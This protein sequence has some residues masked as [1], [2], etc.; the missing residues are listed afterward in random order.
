MS[1]LESLAAELIM[2]AFLPKSTLAN[3]LRRG[4][5]GVLFSL[6]LASASLADMLLDRTEF[7]SMIGE[8]SSSFLAFDL[9]TGA[10]CVLSGSDLETRHAPWSTFKI[11]NALIALETGVADSPDAWRAWDP[12][13]RPAAGYWP[14]DWRQ[15]Q[16]LQSAFQRSAVWYFRDIALEVGAAAYRERLRDWGYGN[17]TV[18]EGSDAFWLGGPL[19]LSVTEQVRF[20]ENLLTGALGVDTSHLAALAQMAQAGSFGTSMLYG[21]TGSG[22]VR[23]GPDAGSFEGWYAGW[24]GQGRKPT[25]VFAHYVLAADFPSLR[26]YRKD[27]AEVLL[28][29][30]GY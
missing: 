29:A 5:L 13:L 3:T 25:V 4:A 8:R 16:T 6:S 24:L 21:K 18:P 2:E 10:E 26:T 11:P 19:A 12:A 20:L 1:R 28:R 14:K 15:D 7:D 27:F 23:S 17:A 22:P 30:C 9:T